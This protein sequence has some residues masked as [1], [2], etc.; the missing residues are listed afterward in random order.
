MADNNRSDEF[1]TAKERLDEIGRRLGSM[2]GQTK[3]PTAG[4][5]LLGSGLLGS[6]QPTRSLRVRRMRKRW[7]A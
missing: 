2:F 5:S 3:V 4:S 1:S 7:P 6:R